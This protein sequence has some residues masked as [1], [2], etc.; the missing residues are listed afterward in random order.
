[1]SLYILQ[2][3]L[4]ISQG[5]FISL[6]II[7]LSSW[8]FRNG[9]YDK[10]ASSIREGAMHFNKPPIYGV[11]LLIL[12]ILNVSITLAESSARLDTFPA[13]KRTQNACSDSLSHKTL[14]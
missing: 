2:L 1:M 4:Y 7:L 8:N 6:M 13:M 12:I 9:G 5:D 11:L 3:Q 14:K 10:Q